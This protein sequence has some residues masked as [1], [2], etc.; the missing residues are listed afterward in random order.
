L[1]FLVAD[2]G[3]D[4]RAVIEKF[5]DVVDGIGRQFG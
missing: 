2:M 3:V 4:R 5:D 1:G